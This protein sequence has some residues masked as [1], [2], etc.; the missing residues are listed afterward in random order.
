MEPEVTEKQ[1][2][3]TVDQFNQQALTAV[4]LQIG[5]FKSQDNA[6]KLQKKLIT[7]QITNSR[8]QF[9]SNQGNEMYKVQIGPID[10][11][12]QADEVNEKLAFLGMI[13]TQLIVEKNKASLNLEKSV[14]LGF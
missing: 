1:E 5:A 8:V 10:S 13:D 3:E 11:E 7:G 2:I 12:H 4:Y 9:S 6:R 14:A